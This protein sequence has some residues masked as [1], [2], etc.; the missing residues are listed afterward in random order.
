MADETSETPRTDP[1]PAARNPERIKERPYESDWAS[2]P[3]AETDQQ[4]EPGAGPEGSV[5]TAGRSVPLTTMAVGFG[6][7]FITFLVGHWMPLVLGLVLILV[8]GVWSGLTE[9][10]AG[11]MHGVGTLSAKQQKRRE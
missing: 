3:D 4:L 2:L 8:G 10:R 1:A 6:V 7:L 9:R 5:T 11:T